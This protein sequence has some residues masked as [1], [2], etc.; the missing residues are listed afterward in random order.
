[1]LM[2][3]GLRVP[4]PV[5]RLVL[6]TVLAGLLHLLGCAHG[7]QPAG[8]PRADSLPV[9]AVV[10]ASSSHVLPAAAGVSAPGDHGI[11]VECAADEPAAA[12]P[13]AELF[14]PPAFGGELLVP[15]AAWALLVGS[16][17]PRCGNGSEGRAEHGR[18]RAVLGV[19]RT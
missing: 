6:L 8:L 14:L 11:A 4:R 13:R 10:A 15:D 5:L 17:A 7:V 12:G 16:R 9:V 19:W 3:V 1:M 2:R 18:T